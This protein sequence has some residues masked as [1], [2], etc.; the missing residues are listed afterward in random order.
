MRKAMVLHGSKSHTYSDLKGEDVQIDNDISIGCGASS[1]FPSLWSSN[2]GETRIN[3][4]RLQMVVDASVCNNVTNFYCWMSCLSIPDVSNA[5]ENMKDGKSL[6]CLDEGVLAST[7]NV[8]A[9]HDKCGP[10][11]H[12][13]GCV[14]IWLPTVPDVPSQEVI[15]DE[16]TIAST[17]MQFCYGGTSMY[18]DGF[19]WTNPTCV[20]YLFPNW[21]LSSAGL[22]TAASIGTIFFGIL[23]EAVISQRRSV[24]Q[25]FPLGWKRLTV[26]TLFYGLQLTLG[27]LIML[28]VMTY[29]GPLF[30]CV[31]FGLMG[32]HAIFNSGSAK[33]PKENKTH[34]LILDE[35]ATDVEPK[36]SVSDCCSGGYAKAEIP[37]GFTPCCQNTL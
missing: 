4:R 27:Y 18:M 9:A 32:G 24:V 21:I 19:H 12:N 8:T 28:V 29:S 20:I 26:S 5:A 6:Y 25:S 35:T 10:G 1:A 17:P 34:D 36:N 11:N 13:D 30:M 3:R 16:E 22:L 2:G 7:N 23:L 15:V 33:A 37:E 31:I 14:G